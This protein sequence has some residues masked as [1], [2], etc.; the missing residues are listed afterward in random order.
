MYVRV[1]LKSLSVISFH[2]SITGA[3]ASCF[4]NICR[5]KYFVRFE[6]IKR[7]VAQTEL[8]EITEKLFP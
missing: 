8:L 6:E 2:I 7:T 1:Y 3:V 5:K 4:E